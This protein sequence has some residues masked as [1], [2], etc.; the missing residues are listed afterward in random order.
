MGAHRRVGHRQ[1]PGADAER[2]RQLGQ[3]LGQS[4]ALRE[5]LGATHADRQIAIAEVEPHLDAELAQPVHD[6]ERVAAQAPAAL[7]D[8]VGEPERDE[9][10]VGRDVGAVDLEVVTGVGDDH[11]VVAD[12]VEHAAGELRA[13][14][15]AGEHDDRR[16]HQGRTGGSG[17]PVMRIPEWAL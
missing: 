17:R 3:R 15:P 4:R 16:T 2:R 1:D 10:G 12:A 13:A 14:G 9:V 5:E 6:R 7:V 8:A 11:E